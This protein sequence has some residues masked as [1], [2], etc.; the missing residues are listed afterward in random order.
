ML[1]YKKKDPRDPCNYRPIYVSTVICSIL[2]HLILMRIA[3]AM[4]PRLLNIQ[5]GALRGG[6]TMTLASKLLNDLHTQDR[7]V[8]LWHVTK[9]FPSVPRSMLT[10]I[11]KEAG[12]PEAIIRILGE[13]SRHT[14]T[15]MFLHGRDLPMRPIRRMKEGCPLH[16][17][18]FLLYYDILL[19]ET[20]EL[21]PQAYLYV[22][23]DDVSV[24]ASTT[25]ALLR[26]LNALHQVAHTMGFRFNKDKI[27]VFHRAKGLQFGAY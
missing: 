13:I 4:T 3:N 19:R 5:H 20:M 27:E 16:P 14:P 18:L 2:S 12:A 11:V 15:M 7:Y 24:R 17:T 21:C 8:V 23:V 25:E 9:A 22:F 1:I 10:N 26:T 6:N